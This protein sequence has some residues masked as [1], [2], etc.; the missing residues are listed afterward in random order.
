M[1]NML[2]KGRFIFIYFIKFYKNLK[3]VTH[4]RI[5]LTSTYNYTFFFLLNQLI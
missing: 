2:E 4:I 3:N 5:L 1:N